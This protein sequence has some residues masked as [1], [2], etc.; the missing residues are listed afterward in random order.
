[1]KLRLLLLSPS[2]PGLVPFFLSHVPWPWVTLEVD[3]FSLPPGLAFDKTR[4]Q[5]DAL[6]L[7]QALPSPTRGEGILALTDTDLYLPALTFVFGASLHGQ[8]RSVLSW[9]RL[10]PHPADVAL[11]QRRVLV[12][13]VHEL[14]HGLGLSHCVFAACPMH[15]SFHPD[16]VD[17]KEPTYCASCR[18]QLESLLPTYL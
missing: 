3:N 18:S 8:R 2:F 13:A 5:A 16:T 10:H 17:L 7:L 9:A 15:Q 4:Q 14:G 1:V 6:K 11:F 12:E